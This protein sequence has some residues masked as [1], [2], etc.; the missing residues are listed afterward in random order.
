MSPFPVTPQNPYPVHPPCFNDSIPPPIHP[1]P[2]TCPPIT[3]HWDTETSQD[4]GPTIH[5]QQGH[6]LLHMQLEPCVTP[7]VLFA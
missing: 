4:Q 5:V 1:L 3:L 6:L 2:L 7:C